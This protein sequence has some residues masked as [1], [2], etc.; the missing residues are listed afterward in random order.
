MPY[1]HTHTRHSP[2]PHTFVES[3][4][5]GKRQ[6]V[7]GM[8]VLEHMNTTLAILSG[9]QSE[10]NAQVKAKHAEP[11]SSP[12]VLRKRRKEGLIRKGS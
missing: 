12:L 2:A 8:K 4:L 6:A 10:L 3:I 1:T 5:S 7:R 9:E 11:E